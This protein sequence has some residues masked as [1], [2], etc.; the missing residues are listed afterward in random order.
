MMPT[1]KGTPPEIASVKST[2][3]RQLDWPNDF[4]PGMS[5]AV[6]DKL[7]IAEFTAGFLGMIKNYQPNDK[8]AMFML[9]ELMMIKAMSYSWKSVRAFYSHVA[10]QVELCR[11]EFNQHPQIREIASIFFKHS[12]LKTNHAT[13]EVKALSSVN[14]DKSNVKGCHQWN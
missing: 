5:D 9:L 12:D 10:K 6:L 11:L 7:D 1:K 8:E 14:T 2:K 4:V 13:K 3:K